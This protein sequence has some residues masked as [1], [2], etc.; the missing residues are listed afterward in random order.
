MVEK[1]SLGGSI[2]EEIHVYLNLDPPPL[3]DMGLTSLHFNTVG[4]ATTIPVQNRCKYF[5]NFL[6][7]EVHANKGLR[8][9]LWFKI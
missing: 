7:T 4:T 8:H 2:G 5:S 1:Y 3:H 9:N 6:N